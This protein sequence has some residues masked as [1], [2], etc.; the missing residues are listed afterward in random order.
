MNKV[1]KNEMPL[2]CEGG[3][4]CTQIKHYFPR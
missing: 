4:L 1:V 3:C 2:F